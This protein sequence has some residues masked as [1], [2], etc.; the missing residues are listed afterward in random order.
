MKSRWLLQDKPCVGKINNAFLLGANAQCLVNQWCQILWEYTCNY[1]SEPCSFLS[2]EMCWV[3]HWPVMQETS[4]DVCKGPWWGFMST[5]KNVASQFCFKP[6]CWSSTRGGLHVLVAYWKCR[7]S[8]GF[9]VL[10]PVTKGNLEQGK[11]GGQG[12]KDAN[13]AN[14]VC[15]TTTL[16]MCYS[17]SASDRSLGV[18]FLRLCTAGLEL[19]G[20]R[21]CQGAILISS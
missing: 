21:S 15:E 8:S 6:L 1:T 9:L 7:N 5:C 20:L 3:K 18:G 17:S 4:R 10:G 12:A 2:S 19:N 14:C 11:I 16:L 13:K